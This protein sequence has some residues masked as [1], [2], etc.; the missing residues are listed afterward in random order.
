MLLFSSFAM[1]TYMTDPVCPTPPLIGQLNPKQTTLP[2]FLHTEKHWQRFAIKQ[3]HRIQPPTHTPPRKT[4]RL[5]SPT[6]LLA[7]A[8]LASA[9]SI[10]LHLP[11]TPAPLTL[12]P[13]SHATLTR[14]GQ[15]LSAPL[16]DVHTFVFHNV[17]AGSYLVDV[18]C[19]TDGFMPLRIDVGED[20][21]GD[22]TT[23]VQAWET[24][25]GNDW[26]NKGEALSLRRGS[27]GSAG[28]EVRA[29]GKKSYFMERPKCTFHTHSKLHTR[30]MEE[31]KKKITKANIL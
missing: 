8:Q 26:D 31:K 29:L 10:T 15:R 11:A 1:A 2:S 5:P 28:F 23:E 30:V 17:T 20:K 25:R 19:P 9:A 24:Y 16:S 7:L 13:R 18:H 21:A 22:V 6:G 27:D 14:L 3:S 4:M 12:S